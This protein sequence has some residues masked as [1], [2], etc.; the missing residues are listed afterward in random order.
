MTILNEAHL[1]TITSKSL[2]CS[3]P[4]LLKKYLGQSKLTQQNQEQQNTTLKSEAK[5]KQNFWG[6]SIFGVEIDMALANY[7]SFY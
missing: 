7:G 2:S 3:K 5:S 6:F 4:A 1:K